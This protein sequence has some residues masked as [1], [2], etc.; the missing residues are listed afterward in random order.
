MLIGPC[1]QIQ[2]NNNFFNFLISEDFCQTPHRNWENSFQHKLRQRNPITSHFAKL[3]KSFS[4]V[5]T[6]KIYIN[7]IQNLQKPIYDLVQLGLVTFSQ[8]QAFLFF[9]FFF[10]FFPLTPNTHNNHFGSELEAQAQ[11]IH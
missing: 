4:K 2:R 11:K 7:K 1:D 3:S 6:K 5:V 9:F 10:S 8:N